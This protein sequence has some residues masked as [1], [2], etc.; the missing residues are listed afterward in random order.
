MIQSSGGGG[1]ASAGAGGHEPNEGQVS[2]LAEMGFTPAQARKALRETVRRAPPFINPPS[3][4]MHA[5]YRRAGTQSAPSSGSSHTPTTQAIP[6]QQPSHHRQSSRYRRD[7]ACARSYRIKA[8][9]C[10]QAIMSRI[11][12]RMMGGCSL[13]TRRS[14]RQT[15]R[16]CVRS[17]RSRICMCLSGRLELLLV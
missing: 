5:T 10:T 3:L 2:M 4:L 13:M 7:T 17:G 15:R 6:L 11:Y 9:Q 12:A 8:P 16:A 14:S 1:G